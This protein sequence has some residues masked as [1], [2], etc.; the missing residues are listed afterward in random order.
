MMTT[1][2]KEAYDR[3]RNYF[4]A[5]HA[6]NVLEEDTKILLEYLESLDLKG[7]DLES[8]D[9]EGYAHWVKWGQE[10]ERERWERERAEHLLA[11]Y[12]EEIME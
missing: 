1:R 11:K 12:E 3:L 8:L 4:K 9:L 5:M 2:Q 6:M 10:T 7:Y